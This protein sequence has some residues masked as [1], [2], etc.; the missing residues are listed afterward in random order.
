MDK[1]TYSQKERNCEITFELNGPFWHL[2][3]PGQLTELLCEN[4]MDY[5]FCINLIAI[6][7][8]VAGV[9]VVAFEV[10]SNHIHVVLSGPGTNCNNFF[11]YYKK[12]L[13]RFFS[14]SGRYKDLSGFTHKLIPITS[15][16]MIRSEIPYT[17]RN[18]FL[19]CENY[20]PFSYPWG[21]GQLYFNPLADSVEGVK[22]ESLTVREKKEVC[23]G[24]VIELPSHYE[25][26]NGMLLPKSFCAYKLGMALFRDARHYFSLISKNAEAFSEI[27]KI[28][29]DEVF[30]TD[31]ELFGT[32]SYL[33]KREYGESRPTMLP[34]KDKIDLA[35]RMKQD[36]NASKGQI[37]RML[38]L[39][40]S[41]VNELFGH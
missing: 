37:Q 19:Q 41:V 39:D 36:Y 28:I 22:Y 21:S 40:L 1:I 33:C 2:C 11:A 3:T 27:A 14:Q 17:N 16:E 34:N 7:A 9:I 26:N 10:M 18:A 8:A 30:L 20:T 5:K 31:E 4:E 32:L 23:Q 35:K 6:A 25:V 13:K 15:L 12:K 38:R 29:G 24:R